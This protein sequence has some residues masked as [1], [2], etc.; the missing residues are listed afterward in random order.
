VVNPLFL[1]A[2]KGQGWG[3]GGRIKVTLQYC[4]ALDSSTKLMRVSERFWGTRE[5]RKI[6]WEIREYEPDC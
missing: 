6:S 1:Y 5:R 3:E 4:T 2:S